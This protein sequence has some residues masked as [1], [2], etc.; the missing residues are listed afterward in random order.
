M[1]G[2]LRQKRL[3][4]VFKAG[5]PFLTGYTLRKTFLRQRRKSRSG[6]TSGL[7]MNSLPGKLF[8]LSPLWLMWIA[9]PSFLKFITAT[10]PGFV[11]REVAEILFSQKFHKILTIGNRKISILTYLWA[12]KF[13]EFYRFI[14]YWNEF[15]QRKNLCPLSHLH[16]W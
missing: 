10:I 12:L 3:K 11:E 13:T 14:A 6:I 1:I 7:A 4:S 9:L 2:L 16:H 15:L 8:L 5:S